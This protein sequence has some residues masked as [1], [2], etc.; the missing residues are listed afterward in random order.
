MLYAII[1]IESWIGLC[2]YDGCIIIGTFDEAICS[3]DCCVPYR[4]VSYI[5]G[6]PIIG[7]DI[8]IGIDTAY[9]DPPTD[10]DSPPNAY[11]LFASSARHRD[12]VA[13]SF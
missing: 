12:N 1:G 9:A 10:P 2:M 4:C 13:S 3:P 8:C 7:T 11:A 6:D 5:C